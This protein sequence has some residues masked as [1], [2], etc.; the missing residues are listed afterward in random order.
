MKGDEEPTEWW[1]TFL[2]GLVVGVY[3]HAIFIEIV[4]LCI[5]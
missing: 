5:R 2:L 3:G 4:K 1:R